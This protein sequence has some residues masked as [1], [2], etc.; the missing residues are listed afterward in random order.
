MHYFFIFLLSVVQSAEGSSAGSS[1]H[2]VFVFLDDYGWAN[3]GIHAPKGS[4][5]SVTPNMDALIASGV[6]LDRHH[7][8]KYCS[9]SRSAFHTGRNPIHVNVLNSYMDQHNPS[10]PVSGYQGIP[11]N[12]TTIAQKLKSA[13]YST[14]MVGKWHLGV[15]TP[16][17]TPKGRGYD[18]SLL[19]VRVCLLPVLFVCFSP[20]NI[21][22]QGQTRLPKHLIAHKIHSLMELMITGRP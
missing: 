9:P 21:A 22:T 7:V 5:E 12:M 4:N 17:H 2:L 11:R 13:N 8:F 1:P 10:D 15:A 18:T 16:D 6:N 14:H 19:Y 20:V 3:I